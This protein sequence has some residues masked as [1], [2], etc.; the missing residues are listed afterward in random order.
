MKETVE[1]KKVLSCFGYDSAKN[2]SI[3]QIKVGEGSKECGKTF[4][5][6]LTYNLKRHIANAHPDFAKNEF[7]FA[8]RSRTD[9]NIEI[10]MDRKRYLKT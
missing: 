6:R 3:C 1:S 7:S 4:S 9:G 8:K 5:N 10:T 2:Q